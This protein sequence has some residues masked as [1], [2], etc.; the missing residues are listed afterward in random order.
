M[1]ASG[2]VAGSSRS[3]SSGREQRAR[4]RTRRPRT[5][6]ESAAV[7]TECPAGSM[8]SGAPSSQ[9]DSAPDGWVNAAP[10]HRRAEENGAVAV[11]C[12]PSGAG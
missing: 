3:P 6:Y 7:S 10:L 8:V 4:S 2:T 1:I 12:Q 5:P 9:V 11:R